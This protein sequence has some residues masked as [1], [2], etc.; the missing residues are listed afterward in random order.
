MTYN[1]LVEEV[2]G[3]LQNHAMI[4]S[5]R[6]ATPVEWLNYANNP[7]LPV[8]LFAIGNG[9]FDRSYQMTYAVRVWLLDRSG[10]DGEFE[11]EVISDM[12]SIGR[13]IVNALTLSS[14]PY[15]TQLPIQWN[16]LSEKFD[17]FLSGIT[18]TAIIQT[19][20]TNTYCDSP[21]KP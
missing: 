18:F 4:N 11:T 5:V 6:F 9:S 7:D 20:G 13:D 21:L 16:A 15:A 12:T 1:Q 8:A 10:P 19:T 3:I 17:D 14:K 2:R